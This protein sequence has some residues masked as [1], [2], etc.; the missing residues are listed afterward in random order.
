MELV[1]KQ[2]EEFFE[3]FIKYKQNRTDFRGPG[4]YYNS[5]EAGRISKLYIKAKA[6]VANNFG[7][8]SQYFEQ[9]R[10]N[11][12]KIDR[13]NL[14]IIVGVLEALYENLQR[15][16]ENIKP[17]QKSALKYENIIEEINLNNSIYEEIVNE[18][19]GTYSFHFFTSMYILIRKLLENLIYDCLKQYYGVQ[20]IN[21]FYNTAKNHHHGFGTLIENF[22]IMINETNFKANV[23]DVEQRIIDL[24]KEFQEKGN[25]DTHSLFNLAHQDF[26]EERREK[27]NDLIKKLSFMRV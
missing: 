20:Q 18:I 10:L 25:K 3:E 5:E 7:E 22:K 16:Y 19:N 2:L 27:I 8:E 12:I 6:L 4:P 1:T 26:I 21:K 14:E 11:T 9:I 17:S 15:K 23:G 13:K 24:L